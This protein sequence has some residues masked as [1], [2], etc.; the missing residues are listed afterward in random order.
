MSNTPSKNNPADKLWGG[1]FTA[2]TNEFVEVFT[3]SVGF[4]QR[5]YKQD[6]TGSIAH[7]RMLEHIGVLTADECKAIINGLNDIMI[8]IET[9]LLYTSPSPRD[10]RQSRM[11]SSA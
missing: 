4:D 10:K 11:P 2:P 3:A 6:I 7:A 9:C 5:M 8:D 1:R